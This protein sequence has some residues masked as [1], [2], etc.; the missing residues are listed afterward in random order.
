MSTRRVMFDVWSVTARGVGRTMQRVAPRL[1]SCFGS[2]PRAGHDA[3]PIQ[4]CDGYQG[5]KNDFG[6]GHGRFLVVVGCGRIGILVNGTAAKCEVAHTSA[7]N[8]AMRHLSAFWA[9]LIADEV[10]GRSFGWWLR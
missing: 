4:E 2:S 5:E 3:Q 1:L 10:C 7:R 8:A 6:E 9:R